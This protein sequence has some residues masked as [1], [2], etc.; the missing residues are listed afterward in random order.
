MLWE[1]SLGY[2]MH[3]KLWAL[4]HNLQVLLWSGL[5]PFPPNVPVYS[6]LQTE[7]PHACSSLLT[8]GRLPPGLPSAFFPGLPNPMLLQTL[9]GGCLI[10][11]EY[12]SCSLPWLM[13]I[14]GS[15]ALEVTPSILCVF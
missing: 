3:S 8:I 12:A 14:L 11:G 2:G 10:P 1:F 4:L 6:A 5:G 13:S 7:L 9:I 15:Q